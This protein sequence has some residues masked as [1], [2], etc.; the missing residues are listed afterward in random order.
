M[1]IIFLFAVFLSISNSRVVRADEYQ[2]ISLSRKK[3]DQTLYDGASRLYVASQN[4]HSSKH[5]HLVT[6]FVRTHKKFSITVP[7]S[8][9]IQMCAMNN[10]SQVV[11]RRGTPDGACYLS[12]L[13]G[14]KKTVTDLFEE[15]E[16]NCFCNP[17]AI[18]NIGQVI[19]MLPD[20]D[21]TSEINDLPTQIKIRSFM[22]G[23]HSEVSVPIP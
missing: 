17:T 19:E 6:G 13:D 11:I 22:A 21:P 14:V 4:S 5:F 8:N 1:R 18:S 2:P 20:T 9:F 16:P 15:H 3:F 7:G 12:F 23:T 10:H